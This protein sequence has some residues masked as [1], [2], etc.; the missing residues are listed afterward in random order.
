MYKVRSKPVLWSACWGM[1]G[2]GAGFLFLGKSKAG[3][4][5]G[6]I[7]QRPQP[8]GFPLLVGERLRLVRQIVNGNSQRPR[9]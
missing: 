4:S 5:T 7:Q 2:C 9:L 3:L 1:P 6:V 8:L